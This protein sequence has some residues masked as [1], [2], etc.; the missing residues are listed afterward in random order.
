MPD[1]AK[2]MSYS[3]VTY[4]SYGGIYFQPKS[5]NGQTE[6]AVVDHP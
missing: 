5:V 3:D 4:Y 6:Y 2:E 1:G